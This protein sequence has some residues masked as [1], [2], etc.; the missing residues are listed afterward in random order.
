MLEAASFIVANHM[1]LSHALEAVCQDLQ[2]D[3]PNFLEEVYSY[4]SG[5][6]DKKEVWM[7]GRKLVF[8]EGCGYG[9]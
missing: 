6:V 9:L 3:D 8:K 5:M 4:A 2:Y 1:G 7:E